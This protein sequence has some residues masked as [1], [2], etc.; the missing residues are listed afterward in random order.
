VADQLCT[1]AD[2]SSVLERT[3]IDTTKAT[4]LIETATAVIQA[5]CGRQRIIQV[6]GDVLAIQG[7]GESWLTLPQLPVTTVTSVVLDGVTLT[8][9]ANDYK[10]IGSRLFRQKGWQTNFGWPVDWPFPVWGISGQP[11]NWQNLLPDAS[12]VVVTY[13]HGYAPGAQQLQLGRAACISMITS[14]YGN[15]QSL[16]SE[17]I[18]DYSA[19]YNTLAGTL[20]LSKFMVAALRK[21]YGRPAALTRIG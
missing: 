11:F 6:L 2:I 13:D 15:P 5:V 14:A 17:S 19:T 16:R 21:Q 3:D 20:E 1:V 4:I 10:V 7:L 8:T 12:V 9:A 18:D